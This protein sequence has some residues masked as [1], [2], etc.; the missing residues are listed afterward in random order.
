MTSKKYILKICG[1]INI[2]FLN[3]RK[4]GG[5]KNK[6]KHL[7]FFSFAVITLT[8]PDLKAQTITLLHQSIS[9]SI[10]GLSIVDD[11]VAWLSG[12][13]GTVGTTVD[14]GKTW[15]WSQVK[16]FEQIDFR[17]IEAFSDKEAIIMSS[18][19]PAVILKTIDGG[20]NWLVTYQN[21]D[22][23]FFLDAMEFDG[24]N[25]G[26]IL[27]DP[28]N[29][30]FLI[31]QTFNGGKNWTPAKNPPTALPNEAAFAA[32]GTCLRKYKTAFIMV[33]GGSNARMITLTKRF[34]NRP[35]SWNI[36]I[37]HGKASQGAFSIAF[38]HKQGIIVG[39]DYSNDSRTDSVAVY[40]HNA[41]MHLS[42]QQPSGYQSCVENIKENVYLSTGT[43]G[44]S[45]T[46]D[47]G[48]TWHKIDAVSYN[49]CRKA[50][51]GSLILLAGDDGKIG[52]Y[53]P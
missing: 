26:I 8:S 24:H 19:T 22:K 6:L 49:V 40:M 5:Y 20:A 46:N 12:S 1:H 32:S 48:K 15:A 50:K 51:H 21:N 2:L 14:G 39:G 11:R 9:S 38:G 45:L 7:L 53:K 27:G 4:V 16:G 30:K 41:S 13:K 29:R 31:L 33:T 42:A 18:G 34:K 10:R 44:S 35:H 28:I 43:P 25:N 36:P 23:A 17:D 3:N 52:I 37:L 47:G